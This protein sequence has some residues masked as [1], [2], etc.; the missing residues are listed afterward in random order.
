MSNGHP[1]PGRDGQYSERYNQR[2]ARQILPPLEDS[3]ASLGGNK[4]KKGNKKLKNRVGVNE[5]T[6]IDNDS[7]M[8]FNTSM[9]S[10]VSRIQVESVHQDDE[11]SDTVIPVLGIRRDPFRKSQGRYKQDEDNDYDSRGQSNISSKK[12]GKKKKQTSLSSDNDDDFDTLRLS[13]HLEDV[14]ELRIASPD[15]K[16]SL[17]NGM[18]SL[19]QFGA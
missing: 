13:Q 17:S 15:T 6:E 5:N 16:P 1:S 2:S 11:D 3:P 7:F 18:Y 10:S 4:E 12:K 9:T 8:N 14:N 19:C